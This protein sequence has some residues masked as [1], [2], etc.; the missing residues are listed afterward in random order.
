MVAWTLGAGAL[1]VVAILL[2][3]VGPARPPSAPNVLNAWCG[4]LQRVAAVTFFAW[5][6]R[7]GWVFWLIQRQSTPNMCSAR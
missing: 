1:L 5:L 3:R 7:F 4:A 6:F 2:L